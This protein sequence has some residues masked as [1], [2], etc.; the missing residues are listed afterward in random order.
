MV[1]YWSH[2]VNETGPFAP[3]CYNRERAVF[4]FFVFFFLFFYL[5]I[6]SFIYCLVRGGIYPQIWPL[7]GSYKIEAKA[8]GRTC[9]CGLQLPPSLAHSRSTEG[10]TWV[11]P[12]ELVK[13]DLLHRL[14]REGSV[15]MDPPL[16]KAT[17]EWPGFYLGSAFIPVSP[18]LR[19][20][21]LTF[22]SMLP[23]T[24]IAATLITLARIQSPSTVPSPVLTVAPSIVL[25]ASD[26]V[27]LVVISSSPLSSPLMLLDAMTLDVCPFSPASSILVTSGLIRFS[28]S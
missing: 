25:L 3:D 5:S 14:Q 26:P 24:K 28:M 22:L 8:Q 9:G 4:F 17:Q 20:H 27:K 16:E 6:Y 11:S 7:H 1:Q 23:L 13:Q 15:C 19:P 18:N 12:L 21:S 10:S 2:P